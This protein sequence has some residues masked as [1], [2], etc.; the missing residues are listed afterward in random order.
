MGRA[1]KL[2]WVNWYT[3]GGYCYRSTSNVDWDG[4]RHFKKVAKMLGET[5]T[6]EEM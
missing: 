4:V 5:I 3:S 2:Y 1:K 6:Y